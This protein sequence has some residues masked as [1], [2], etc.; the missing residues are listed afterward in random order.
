MP[1]CVHACVRASF[2][3]LSSCVCVCV[4][5]FVLAWLCCRHVMTVF[6]SVSEQQHATLWWLHMISIVV[7]CSSMPVVCLWINFSVAH[8]HLFSCLPCLSFVFVLS[9]HSSFCLA[10][11]II[12][13]YVT[14][15]GHAVV[16]G[17]AI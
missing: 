6:V 15:A 4:F 12:V 13:P 10:P 3:L 7:F 2:L 9:F 16:R 17:R 14:R 5:G 11:S 1:P 8:T